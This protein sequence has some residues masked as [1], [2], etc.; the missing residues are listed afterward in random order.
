[1]KFFAVAALLTSAL[2][3]PT[4]DIESRSLL[5]PCGVSVGFSIPSCCAASVLDVAVL[6]C[7]SPPEAPSLEAPFS[8]ICAAKGRTPKCCSIPLAGLALFCKDPVGEY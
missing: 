6:D 1:M 8:K 7:R 4:P 3:V 2:A 5:G